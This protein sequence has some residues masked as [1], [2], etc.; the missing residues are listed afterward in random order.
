M[1]KNNKKKKQ[2][3][4]KIL[5]L[6]LTPPKH[7]PSRHPDICNSFQ[8]DTMKKSELFSSTLANQPSLSLR[9]PCRIAG[10]WYICL[11][12]EVTSGLLRQ[13]N[14][15]LQRWNTE[16]CMEGR[17]SRLAWWELLLT[18]LSHVVVVPPSDGSQPLKAHRHRL[19]PLACPCFSL[20]VLFSLAWFWFCVLTPDCLL[21][22]GPE[23]LPAWSQAVW[24][25]TAVTQP[26]ALR[27]VLDHPYTFFPLVIIIIVL[28]A[29]SE[30]RFIRPRKHAVL[31]WR[32][33]SSQKI[34][35]VPLVLTWNIPFDTMS[36]MGCA[37]QGQTL[38]YSSYIDVF[39]QVWSFYLFIKCL[40]FK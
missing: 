10:Y 38:C 16:E 14:Q 35:K 28:R 36:Q 4:F 18:C 6:Q 5:T 2:Q 31:P 32:S 40:L 13:A 22:G 30:R 7:C 3:I 19:S 26:C 24:C 8:G 37:G 17:Q 33:C 21:R 15:P 11:G 39:L 9:E 20:L 27:R 29:S 34:F 12:V 23:S 25:E 1:T